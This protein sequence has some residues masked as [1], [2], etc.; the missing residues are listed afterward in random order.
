[1]ASIVAEES[2]DWVLDSAIPSPMVVITT[3]AKTVA[4]TLAW[5][6]TY[7]VLNSMTGG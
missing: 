3:A 6:G 1:M 7:L 5:K 4:T 2:I